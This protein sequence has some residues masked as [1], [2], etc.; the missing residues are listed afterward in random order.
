MVEPETEIQSEENGQHVQR[1]QGIQ[2]ETLWAHRNSWHA[3]LPGR[4]QQ[5]L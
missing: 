4:S 1:M 3:T 5:T 2:H